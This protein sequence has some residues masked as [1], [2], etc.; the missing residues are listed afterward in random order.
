MGHPISHKNG[1]LPT[2]NEFILQDGRTLVTRH[3]R[4]GDIHTLSEIYCEA[5]TNNPA[6]EEWTPGTAEGL[7]NDLFYGRNLSL[8]AEVDGHVV[9]ATIAETRRWEKGSVIMEVK[10][11]FVKPG[12]Q[13]LGI[14]SQLLLQNLH[15]AEIWRGVTNVELI[16]FSDKEGPVRFYKKTGLEPIGDLVIMAGDISKHREGLMTGSRLSR[17]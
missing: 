7:L 15:R 9:G 6:G 2:I 1:A 4:P 10:E 11:F 17:K 3:M 16:T 8:V 14:G 13:R 5:Y 12:F